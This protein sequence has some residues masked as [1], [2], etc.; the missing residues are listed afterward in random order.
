MPDNGKAERFIQTSLREWIYGAAYASSGE[1]TAAMAPW[2]IPYNTKRP[3]SAL[4]HLPP[5]Q[6]LNNLLG[7]GIQTNPYP[8]AV[9]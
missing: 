4:K 8:A 3:H 2:L 9:K 5:W 7:K 1:R 6:R